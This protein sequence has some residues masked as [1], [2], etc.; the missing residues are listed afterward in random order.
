MIPKV[1]APSSVPV[2]ERAIAARPRA[3]PLT[4]DPSEALARVMIAGLFLAFAIRIGQNFLETG[5]LTGL[6]LLVSEML[7][8]V[9][10][11]SRRTAVCVDRAW[12]VRAVAAVSMVGPP[13]VRPTT[14][15]GVVPEVYPVMLSVCGLLIVI[16]GKLSLGRSFGLLPA[17]RGVVCSGIYRFVR[18][19][20][21]LGYLATHVA[22]LAANASIWNTVVLVVADSALLGRTV[23][24]ER[25]LLRDP[26][27]ASYQRR[28]RWRILPGVV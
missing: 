26:A 20:I 7:V 23:Y 14:E 10:T 17:N 3:G 13:L 27:Y 22:F 4:R 25:V 16:V 9:L 21:Y 8:V 6:L 2:A 11:L 24:E 19:P 15:S 12:I 1:S 28:V 18:H 5:R